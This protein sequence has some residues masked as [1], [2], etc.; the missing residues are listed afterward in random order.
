MP[1]INLGA[2]YQI[3]GT[4][5]PW[6]RRGRRLGTI[7]DFYTVVRE[8]ASHLEQCSIEAPEVAPSARRQ[9]KRSSRSRSIYPPDGVPRIGAPVTA[10]QAILAVPPERDRHRHRKDFGL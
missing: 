1:G 8:T 3:K 9:R 2:E 6:L 5:D 4:T 7:Q 10:V